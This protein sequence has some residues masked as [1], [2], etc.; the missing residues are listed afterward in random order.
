MTVGT[1]INIRDIFW[2][3]SL[4][5]YEVIDIRTA[6]AK[7]STSKRPPGCDDK[8]CVTCVPVLCSCTISSSSGV[9]RRQFFAKRSRR[10]DRPHPVSPQ[11]SAQRV[12]PC[13][14]ASR[15]HSKHRFVLGRWLNEKT[16]EAACG[17]LHNGARGLRVT[18]SPKMPLGEIE[19]GGWKI[20]WDRFRQR[21]QHLVPNDV[22]HEREACAA[23]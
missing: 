4:L 22:S 14:A 1:G 9:F 19:A 2:M 10:F 16:G 23:T 17:L 20:N 18:P 12:L 5:K 6:A 15:R 8:H 11:D 3:Y 13:G 7:A 21:G